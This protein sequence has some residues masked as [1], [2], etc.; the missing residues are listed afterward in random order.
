MLIM[1][2]EDKSYLS[3]G[4]LFA[5]E[6]GYAELDVHSIRIDRESFTEVEKAEN[7]KM[8][9]TMNREE[10]NAYCNLI[11]DETSLKIKPLIEALSNKFKIY[12]YK[13]DDIE[14]RSKWDLFFWC[15][16]GNDEGRDLSYITLSTNTTKTVKERIMDVEQVIE[17][18]KEI[19][20]NGIDISI[21]YCIKYDD[22]KLK[23]MAASYFETIRNDFVNYS[24]QDG[25]IKVI[26]TDYKGNTCYGFFKKGAR[27]KYRQVSLQNM[28]L[29]A[30]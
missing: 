3:S 10:W 22:E 8:Y 2:K 18:I 19:G 14:Y 12:Q 9:D 20:F 7:S 27:S 5:I 24:G 6:R 28:T 25:K 21:Q 17:A 23:E 11:P 1:I 30:M 15:N 4:D 29:M 26:G 13:H 16:S